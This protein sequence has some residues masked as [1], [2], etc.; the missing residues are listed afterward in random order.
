MNEIIFTPEQIELIRSQIAPNASDDELRLFLLQAQ[1]RGLDPFARQIYLIHRWDATQRRMVG[2]VASMGPRSFK[3]GNRPTLQWLI[4]ASIS[5]QRITQWVMRALRARFSPLVWHTSDPLS[6]SA[7]CIW[8][9]GRLPAS[10]CFVQAL[11][12]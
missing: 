8:M 2:S 3:R 12:N 11:L 1:R 9:L 10:A 6:S 5:L 7:H 4:I